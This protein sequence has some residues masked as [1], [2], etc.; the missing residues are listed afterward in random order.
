MIRLKKGIASRCWENLVLF[1]KLLILFMLWCLQILAMLG[2]QFM[3]GDE[4]CGAVVSIRPNVSMLV[5][6]IYG[7]IRVAYGY[8][9]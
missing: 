9:F 7:I 1:Y 4:I 2:E 5:Y 3:V 8:L 6:I